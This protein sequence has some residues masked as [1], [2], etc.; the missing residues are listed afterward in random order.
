LL[1]EAKLTPAARSRLPIVCDL[2][3]PIWAP[4]VCYD[5]RIRI[6]E[7]TTRSLKLKFESL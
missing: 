5:E 1:S 7:R 2:L 4:G 6:S 3:G